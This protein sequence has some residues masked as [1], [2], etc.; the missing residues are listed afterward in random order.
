MLRVALVA[1]V[2]GGGVHAGNLRERPES[3]HHVVPGVSAGHKLNPNLAIVGEHISDPEIVT[4]DEL[5]GKLFHAL[6]ARV[7]VKDHG[8]RQRCESA[9]N[10]LTDFAPVEE[11]G[12]PVAEVL[13][14]FGALFQF[15]CGEP[16]VVGSHVG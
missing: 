1:A 6:Q 9:K 10:E 16:S 4:E 5:D 8:F 12:Q 7:F 14:R 2:V 11:N 3:L 15:Q 13:L